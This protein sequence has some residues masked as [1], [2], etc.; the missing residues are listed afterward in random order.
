MS[1]DS[2]ISRRCKFCNK[3]FANRPN[4]VRHSGYYC[5]QNPNKKV[6]KQIP[7]ICDSLNVENKAQDHIEAKLQIKQEDRRSFYKASVEL[8]DKEFIIECASDQTPIS[9]IL[10][11]ILK[12]YFNKDLPLNHSIKMKSNR[13]STVSVYHDDSWITITLASAVEHIL[14][15]ITKFFINSSEQFDIG[16]DTL[17]DI[18]DVCTSKHGSPNH[19]RLCR[20]IKMIV[21]NGTNFQAGEVLSNF[22]KDSIEIVQCENKQEIGYIYLIHVREFLNQNL[23]VYK[24]GKAK[25]LYKRFNQYPKGSRLIF[26]HEVNDYHEVEKHLLKLL[27]NTKEIQFRNDIGSEYFEG[28]KDFICMCIC[29]F[30]TSMQASA[31]AMDG[32]VTPPELVET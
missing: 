27:R 23:N 32:P 20:E 14:F 29:Q 26:A 2:E 10:K 7:E 6:K 17:K 25:D 1:S 13:H 5:D 22:I 4:R 19:R 28:E 12:I 31:P 11:L 16:K 30:L 18:V 21:M 8:I 3:I 24:F 9:G 15:A